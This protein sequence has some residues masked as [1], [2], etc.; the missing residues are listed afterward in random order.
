[1]Y[2]SPQAQLFQSTC[3]FSIENFASYNFPYFPSDIK[4]GSIPFHEKV[5]ET[6]ALVSDK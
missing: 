2:G 1:M 5:T 3:L 4:L 6:T